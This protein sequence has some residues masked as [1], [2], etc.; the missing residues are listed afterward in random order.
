MVVAVGCCICLMCATLAED[1]FAE[2]VSRFVVY[3]LAILGR[4]D[5]WQYIV[6]C[7]TSASLFVCVA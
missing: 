7:L 4:L 5:L 6:S 2:R 1:L 3:M